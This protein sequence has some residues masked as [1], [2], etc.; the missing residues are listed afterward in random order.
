MLSLNTSPRDTPPASISRRTFEN[1]T[2]D[3][4]DFHL[5]VTAVKLLNYRF[6]VLMKTPS[7][8]PQQIRCNERESVIAVL[9]EQ[10]QELKI[11]HFEGNA[12]L[13]YAVFVHLL[14]ITE[15]F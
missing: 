14:N 1:Q 4:S 13:T 11:E 3:L 12:G 5:C 10:G 7:V 2:S 15:H 8:L 6:S 9:I